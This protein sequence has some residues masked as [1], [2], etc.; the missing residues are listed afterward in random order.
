MPIH[1]FGVIAEQS[2][3]SAAPNLAVLLKN[4]QVMHSLM[5]A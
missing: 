5:I 1:F 2:A 4:S 3:I